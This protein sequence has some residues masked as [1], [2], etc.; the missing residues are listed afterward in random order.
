MMKKILLNSLILLLSSFLLLQAGDVSR[1]G[2][3]SGTQLLIPVGARSLAMGG[4]P[5][6]IISGAEATFWNPAG[7]SASPKSEVLFNNM[8][9]IADIDV[10]YLSLTFNGGNI[11]AFGLDIKSLSFGRID[12][13]TELL[14]NG[15][16]NTYT[17]TFVVSGLTYAR[18]L[19]D[20]I[21]AGV[22]GKVVYESIMETSAST[23]ALDMGVQYTFGQKLF[24]GV[25]MKNV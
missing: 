21:T 11:G 3:T 1:L 13:T 7:I 16:G 18:R 8:Q 6:G 14:P 24:F 23:L 9:Y 25:V 5:L 4:A 19:T 2:T 12:E 15:T 20:R 10:N 17:P 22:T